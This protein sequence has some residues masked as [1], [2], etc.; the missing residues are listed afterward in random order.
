MSW[1]PKLE[2]PALDAYRRMASE[3]MAK[4]ARE[5]NLGPDGLILRELRPEDIGASSADFYT[6]VGATTWTDIISSQT[7]AD[8]RFVGINGI[9]LQDT[10]GTSAFGLEV[11]PAISQVKITRKGSV[12]RYWVV[13]PVWAFESRVGYCDDPITVD[14]NT[15]L[16]VSAWARTASSLKGFTLLGAVVEKRGLLINP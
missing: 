10:P 16:T 4:A 8:N 1:Y 15:T 3:L 13:K 5:L 6:G 12:T 9:M 7:I 2:G 11:E 14:Q